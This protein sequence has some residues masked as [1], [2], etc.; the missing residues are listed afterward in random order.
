MIESL[1]VNQKF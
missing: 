1:N